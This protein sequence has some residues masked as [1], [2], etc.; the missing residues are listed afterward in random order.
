MNCLARAIKS[1]SCCEDRIFRLGTKAALIW[2]LCFCYWSPRKLYQFSFFFGDKEG[3]PWVKVL[4]RL[5]TYSLTKRMLFT[6]RSSTDCCCLL[7]GGEDWTFTF[8]LEVI[9]LSLFIFWELYVTT[10]LYGLG[11]SPKL[12]ERK[13]ELALIGKEGTSNPFKRTLPGKELTFS[14]SEWIGSARC[15][16]RK[17]T[18][19]WPD[20]PY[21]LWLR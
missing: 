4:I 3:Y 16:N 18:L 9:A 21:W 17:E 2:L 6:E 10:V 19:S 15:T 11:K 20:F 12:Q 8:L 5:S 1:S 14:N 13:I 7:F